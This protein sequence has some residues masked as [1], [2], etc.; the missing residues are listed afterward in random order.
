MENTG[1]RIQVQL[2]LMLVRHF[3]LILR[4]WNK[5]TTIQAKAVQATKVQVSSAF[6]K[7]SLDRHLVLQ[8]M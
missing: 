1:F 5:R 8:E 3:Y 2:N 4:A 7:C 6:R